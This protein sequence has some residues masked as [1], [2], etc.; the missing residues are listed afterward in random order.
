MNTSLRC[1]ASLPL[2]SVLFLGLAAVSTRPVQAQVTAADSAAVLIGTARAFEARERL[3]VAEALYRLVLERYGSTTAAEAARERLA[4]LVARGGAANGAVETQVWMTLYGA[5]LGVAV[6]LAF[7]ADSPEAYGVGLLLGG[8]SGFLA[9]RTLAR[10][11]DLTE[12]QARA[13]TFGGT[14]GTWQGLGWQEVFDIGIDQTCGPDLFG[15]GEVCYA[16][17]DSSE[18]MFAA[19]I[20][21]GLTGI[22]AGALLSRRNITPGTGTLVN[23]GALWGTWFGVAGGT[24]AGLDGNDLLATTLVSGD[25]ALLATALL[26]PRWNM[27]RSRAR[28]ISIAGVLGGLAGAG[29]DLI[30][31]PDN[32]KVLMAIP[33]AGSIIGL[34]VGALATRNEDPTRVG[35]VGTLLRLDGGRL[36]LGTPVP[37]PTMVRI[38]GPRGTRWEPAMGLHLFRTTF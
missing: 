34:T 20:A 11:L 13:I 10:A 12:G 8:P 38:D 31:Q 21:G 7:G 19:M 27:T 6:P 37:V 16:N 35:A 26:A 32:E 36:A 4:S 23:F 9:G 5:W 33:L 14:W 28:L 15:G 25:V 3:D 2:V 17:E 22:T 30:A 18:E 1:P 29:L 24:I